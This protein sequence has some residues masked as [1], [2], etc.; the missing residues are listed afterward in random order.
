LIELTTANV[1]G[2]Y[3]TQEEALREV[4]GMLRLGG[5]AAVA[6]LALG[7][8]DYPTS[9]GRAIADGAELA[10]LARRLEDGNR[11]NGPGRGVRPKPKT[12]R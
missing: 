12:R 4:A 7:F 2:H 8:D 1:V 3:A 10:A 11:A 6:T 5:E 9:P